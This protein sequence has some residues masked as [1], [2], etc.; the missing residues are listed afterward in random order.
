MRRALLLGLLIAIGASA[1]ATPLAA[2]RKLVE[3]TYDSRTIEQRVFG[4]RA[5][6]GRWMSGRGQILDR[7]PP[8]RLDRSDGA[9]RAAVSRL[10]EMDPDRS[11][12][13]KQAWEQV[14]R[15]LSFLGTR[16]VRNRSEGIDF[17]LKDRELVVQETRWLVERARGELARLLAK[18]LE[19]KHPDPAT[20]GRVCDELAA[21]HPFFANPFH[22]EL[23]I[24]DLRGISPELERW[25]FAQGEKGVGF[26]QL[27]K[28]MQDVVRQLGERAYAGA[29]V[30]IANHLYEDGLETVDGMRALGAEVKNVRYVT[31]PYPFDKGVIAEMEGR[32]V[33][34]GH[35]KYDKAATREH[36]RA[37]VRKLLARADENHGPILVVDDGAIATQVIAEEFADQLYRFRFLELTKGGERDG[38]AALTKALHFDPR[39]VQRLDREQLQRFGQRWVAAHSYDGLSR[40]K[41]EQRWKI[42]ADALPQA[43]AIDSQIWQALPVRQY[44]FSYTTYSNFDYKREVMTP[45]YAEAVNRAFLGALEH[46]G[47]KLPNNR[48]TIIGAG[49]MGVAAGMQL[50]ARGFEVT[51]YEPDPGRRAV[52][53][54][55]FGISEL[56]P[57]LKGRGLILEMSGMRKILRAEHLFLIDDGAFLAHARRKTSRST[58]RRSR[59]W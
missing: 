47:K 24:S 32:G 38:K 27:S 35:A 16:R 56:E 11:L 23:L 21:G 46:E 33:A 18:H 17:T 19:D 57:A 31:T 44:G 29:N 41:A 54:E 51:F 22:V 42:Y 48:V 43:R 37:A 30:L 50:K 28:P 1:H 7:L 15:G 49:A 20:L 59:P 25:D 40:G 3:T 36:V 52:I 4:A 6:G 53:P 34:V 10:L 58:W 9:L 13:G 45:H 39:R 26:S 5:K 2:R 12:L 14:E 55:G 8:D